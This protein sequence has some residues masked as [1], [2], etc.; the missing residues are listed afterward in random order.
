[1]LLVLAGVLAYTT[2]QWGGVVRTGRYQYLLILGLLAMFLSL[3]RSQD[4]WLPLPGRVLRCAS[5]EN[6]FAD[7]KHVSETGYDPPFLWRV[8]AS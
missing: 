6:R 1:M 2:F 5:V 3:G 7:S 8:I 4:E